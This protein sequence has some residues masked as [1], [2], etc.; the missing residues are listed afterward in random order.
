[1]PHAPNW[2]RAIFASNPAPETPAGCSLQ[3]DPFRPH[4]AHRREESP[5]PQGMAGPRAHITVNVRLSIWGPGQ[6]SQA[7]GWQSH[8]EEAVASF[9]R[10]PSLLQCLL[11]PRRA[12]TREEVCLVVGAPASWG[13]G[14][15]RG[16]GSTLVSCPASISSCPSGPATA[17]SDHR[18]PTRPEAKEGSGSLGSEIPR[19]AVQF[20][21]AQPSET[22]EKMPN[23]TNHQGNAQGNAARGHVTPRR[24]GVT[25]KTRNAECS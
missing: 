5:D 15:S 17:G 10:V 25:P 19:R 21:P 18:G 8:R 1:M 2:S 24:V 22:H 3:R 7:G 11:S 14:L 16:G 4:H 20:Q 13:A 9:W 6:G 23:I 12:P